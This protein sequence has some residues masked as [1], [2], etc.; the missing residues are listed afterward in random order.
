MGRISDN[1]RVQTTIIILAQKEAMDD[2]FPFSMRPHVE[3]KSSTSPPVA[4]AIK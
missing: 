1:C 2:L 3:N 4:E